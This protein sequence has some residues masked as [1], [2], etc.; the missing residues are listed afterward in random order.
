MTNGIQD[1]QGEPIQVG[2]TVTTRIRG[3]KHEGKVEAIVQNEQDIKEAGGLGINVKNPPKVVYTDQHGHQ[4]SHNPGT[5]THV[6]NS[7][8]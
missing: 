1:K 6:D 7:N 8:D 4:V 2:D 3:G 5:L